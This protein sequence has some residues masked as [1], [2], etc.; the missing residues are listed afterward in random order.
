MLLCIII[1]SLPN[2]RTPYFLV[3]CSLGV[4]QTPLKQST[5]MARL[6]IKISNE[7]KKRFC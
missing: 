7:E 2:V 5:T 1:A 3:G 6:E 4:P